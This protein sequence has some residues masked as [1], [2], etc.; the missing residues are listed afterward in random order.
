MNDKRIPESMDNGEQ[1]DRAMRQAVQN[2]LRE[3][4]RRGQYIV[5]ERNGKA[6]RIPPEEIAVP[7]EAADEKD[8]PVP[9]PYQSPTLPSA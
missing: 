8:P 1:V 5:V 9:A 7:D 3:H 6:V 2:A 4:K